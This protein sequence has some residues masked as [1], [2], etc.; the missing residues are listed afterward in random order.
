MEMML[1]GSNSAEASPPRGGGTG[2]HLGGLMGI[3][4]WIVDQLFVD[5]IFWCWLVGEGGGIF[6]G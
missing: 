2:S 6:G 3:E 4:G 1:E 5:F